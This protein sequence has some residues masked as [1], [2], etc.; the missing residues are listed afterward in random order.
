M[1]LSM[2]G[3]FVLCVLVSAFVAA[4]ARAEERAV[5]AP[6]GAW[7]VMGETDPMT[8]RKE[9]TA[10]YGA[11]RA[12]Q[13]TKTSFAISYR[14]RGMLRGYT[15]RFGD[16]PPLATALPTRTE[17]RIGVLIIDSGEPRWEQ[18][19]TARR[20]R[21]QALTVLSSIVNDDVDLTRLSEVLAR[22][23]GPGCV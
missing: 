22:L 10:Y 3:K 15:I 19:V 13:L 6:I 16:D 2:T 9:C 18:L 7:R 14:N 21:V 17:E 23:S 12:I 20:V 5:G 8:D 4:P 11:G 1:R